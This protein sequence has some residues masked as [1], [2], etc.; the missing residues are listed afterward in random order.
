MSR[1]CRYEDV[2]RYS[3]QQHWTDYTAWGGYLTSYK[4]HYFWAKRA[5]PFLGLW[6]LS[7]SVQGA[8]LVVR[9]QANGTVAATSVRPRLLPHG[10]LDAAL[11][12]EVMPEVCR[13]VPAVRS[14]HS[15]VIAPLPRQGEKAIV[16]D[17][18]VRPDSMFAEETAIT[19]L[20]S[21]EQD[22]RLALRISMLDITQGVRSV[23]S[24]RR[25]ARTTA[26]PARSFT[27]TASTTAPTTTATTATP[28]AAATAASTSSEI[29]ENVGTDPL[30]Q[31][32][33]EAVTGLY[34][35]IYGPHGFELISV[36]WCASSGV[37]TAEKITGDVN[38]PASQA[39]FETT[40]PFIATSDRTQQ[41][42]QQQQQQCECMFGCECFTGAAANTPVIYGHM[43]ARAKTAGT[44]Y[45]LPKWFECGA[46]LLRCIGLAFVSKQYIYCTVTVYA[47]TFGALQ[48]QPLLTTT[49]YIHVYVQL[50]CCHTLRAL[51]ELRQS[52]VL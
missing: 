47:C 52:S 50:H 44:G 23:L 22:P 26:A 48:C 10:P 5:L 34:W 20:V 13:I 14:Q 42:Q 37:L 25:A 18:T 39:T 46:S 16:I 38:V 31:N 1:K 4:E 28:A 15:V 2:E 27:D 7:N 8:L 41:Q 11:N 9:V 32:F 36:S 21:T 17:A 3:K 43:E 12:F 30:M 45:H 49:A 29:A 35:A 33:P 19:L 40:G 51:Q 24:F 6:A